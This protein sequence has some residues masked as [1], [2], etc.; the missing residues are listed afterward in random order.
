MKRT[1]GNFYKMN[2][3]LEVFS[4]NGNFIRRFD[5]RIVTFGF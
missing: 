4:Q 1:F 5:F 3:S 2:F